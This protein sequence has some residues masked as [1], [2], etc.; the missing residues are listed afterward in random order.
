[1]TKLKKNIVKGDSTKPMLK[2]SRRFGVRV[3]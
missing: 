1:M 2:V 3:S